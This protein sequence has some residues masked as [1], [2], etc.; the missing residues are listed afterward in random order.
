[1]LDTLLFTK[2]KTASFT[3]HIHLYLGIKK[4]RKYTLLRK[5]LMTLPSEILSCLFAV[6]THLVCSNLL[7]L[8]QV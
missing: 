1:M 6:S 8:L 7:I 2:G 4:K 3:H 5:T